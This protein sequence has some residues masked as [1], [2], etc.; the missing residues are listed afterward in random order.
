MV[1]GKASLFA[2]LWCLRFV[3]NYSSGSS[4]NVS[5]ETAPEVLDRVGILQ[6]YSELRAEH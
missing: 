1:S 2:S 3:H 6:S 5:V 4:T